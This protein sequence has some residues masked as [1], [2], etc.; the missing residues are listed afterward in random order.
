M[1]Y[2][3]RPAVAEKPAE[4]FNVHGGLGGRC[5][6]AGYQAEMADRLGCMVV[7]I[8]YIKADR[9]LL[10]PVWCCILCV[11]PRN[12][13]STHLGTMGYL[14]AVIF[15]LVRSDACGRRNIS[16]VRCCATRS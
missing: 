10:C 9:S 2:L 8:N 6:A 11:M 13:V 14:L 5:T 15:V 4:V 12:T 16:P 3:H 7:N 1:T